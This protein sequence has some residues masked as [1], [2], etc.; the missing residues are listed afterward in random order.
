MS[1]HVMMYHFG[2]QGS[3]RYKPTVTAKINTCAWHENKFF[4]LNCLFSI[5]GSQQRKIK[6]QVRS[7]ESHVYSFVRILVH[8]MTYKWNQF[9]ISLPIIGQWHCLQVHTIFLGMSSVQKKNLTYAN[10]ID[11]DQ[12]WHSD[13]VY[14]DCKH[15]EA[16]KISPLK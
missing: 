13:L 10:R 1:V 12:I 11:Q 5:Q 14:T 9:N 4:S 16:L 8:N 3:C 7:F 6:F 2:W 15:L